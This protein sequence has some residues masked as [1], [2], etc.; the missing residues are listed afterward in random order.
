[1]KRII[2]IRKL[3]Y[4]NTNITGEGEPQNKLPGN[5]NGVKG[6][7][8]R[9]FE[10]FLVNKPEIQLND[11]PNNP[12]SQMIKPS[13]KRYI[14]NSSSNVDDKVTLYL[15]LNK[16]AIAYNQLTGIDIQRVLLSG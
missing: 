15:S 3:H 6:Y 4:R 12:P 2:Q 7:F 1:M 5:F 11:Y 16:R 10:N 8:N 13:G 9:E 14:I